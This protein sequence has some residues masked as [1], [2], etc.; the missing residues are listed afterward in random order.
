MRRLGRSIQIVGLVV[1]LS[2]IFLAEGVVGL[3]AMTF[4]F[5]GLL[6][7]AAIFWAGWKIQET[8]EG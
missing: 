4:S 2:G 8:T 1:P 3:P 7:G 5:G 6:V